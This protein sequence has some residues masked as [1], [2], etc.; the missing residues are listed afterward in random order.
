MFA[1]E[2][3]E[4]QIISCKE[5]EDM[6]GWMKTIGQYT[7][8]A[9]E[10]E[11]L[12]AEEEAERAAEREV[13][14]AEDAGRQQRALERQMELERAEEEAA[15][16][17]EAERV[18]QERAAENRREAERL[19]AERAE[20]AA[21]LEAEQAEASA[22]AEAQRLAK[23]EELRVLEEEAAAAAAAAQAAGKEESKKAQKKMAEALQKAQAEAAEAEAAA[24]A[25][26]A[27]ADQAKADA[28]ERVRMEEEQRL[29]NEQRE[30][31]E[32]E[33]LAAQEAARAL[34]LEEAQAKAEREAR[35]E[36]EARQADLE[37]KEKEK[38]EAARKKEMLAKI[39]A[40]DQMKLDATPCDIVMLSAL[41]SGMLHKEGSQGKKAFRERCFVLW[42]HPNLISGDY[43]LFWYGSVK[44]TIPKGH[45]TLPAGQ[46]QVNMPKNRRKGYD[47]CFRIDMQASEEQEGRK[48]I[49][50]A[51]TSDLEGEEKMSLWKK[52]LAKIE[53]DAPAE[54][55]AEAAEAGI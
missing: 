35:E 21:R 1:D 43:T 20:E 44:D 31:E 9:E 6:V 3:S 10:F 54:R 26:A 19:A 34:A 42:R 30:V 8:G 4:K 15:T 51:E 39:P 48:F 45:Q 55:A 17:A 16:A 53:A 28:A 2:V 46:F 22:L 11:R 13:E 36:E 18:A 23:Q 29:E 50:A 49:L 41:C 12:M 32:K 33:R 24:S 5:Y 40:P 52:A 25:A 47:F 38:A 14:E 27:E 7:T 37:R